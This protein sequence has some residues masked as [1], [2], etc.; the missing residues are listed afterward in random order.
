MS[1][2]LGTA[3]ADRGNIFSQAL[4]D[5]NETL[6]DNFMTVVGSHMGFHEALKASSAQ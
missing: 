6:H 3:L 4:Q 1:Y 5:S 2:K